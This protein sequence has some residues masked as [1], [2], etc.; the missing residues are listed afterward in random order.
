MINGSLV[1]AQSRKRY[2]WTNIPNVTLPEDRNI[3]LNDILLGDD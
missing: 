2:F 1:T 3:F